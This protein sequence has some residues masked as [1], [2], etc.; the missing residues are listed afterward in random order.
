[1]SVSSAS[2]TIST[3]LTS[4]IY[5]KSPFNI[6]MPE[7]YNWFSFNVK[8]CV[9]LCIFCIILSCLNI[10]FSG[11]RSHVLSDTLRYQPPLDMFGG[12]CK[13]INGQ[14]Q[15]TRFGD[16]GT[17]D[18]SENNQNDC[19]NVEQ[20][21]NTTEPQDYRHIDTV[22]YQT[23]ELVAP[24]DEFR[25][26]TNLFFGKVHKYVIRRPDLQMYKL[27]IVS[28]LLVL[29]GNV[30]DAVNTVDQTY[31]VF[32]YNS[33]TKRYFTLGDLYK[34]GDGLYKLNYSSDKLDELLQYDRIE[35]MY[36]LDKTKMQ[37]ILTS[38]FKKYT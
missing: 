38:S 10:I 8:I 16:S 23:A 19:E 4:T 27:N 31:R 28:N 30:Y 2:K 15:C 33:R 37:T 36:V 7:L 22:D 9:I 13:C 20:F 5:D 3:D 21:S 34:D 18:M 11:Q 32:L 17:T 29:G 6:T 24:Y 1:M 25:N 26:P 35:I 12:M 14:C